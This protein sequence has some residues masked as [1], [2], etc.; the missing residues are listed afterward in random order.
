MRHWPAALVLVLVVGG[1]NPGGT[2]HERLGDQAAEKGDYTGALAEYQAALAAQPS[3][4]IYAK[5]GA[6]AL[7]K[8]SLREAAEAY[9]NL[10]ADDPSRMDEAATGLDQVAAAAEKG[11]DATAL[12]AAVSALRDIAPER[13]AGRH[14]L[15]LVRLGGLAAPEAQA[16]LP[17]AIAAA[18]DPGVADSLLVAYGAALR[19]TT[20][21]DQAMSAFQAVR[22]R[23]HDGTLLARADSGIAA[24]G[25]Q[26]G[27]QA[28]TVNQPWVAEK[29][30]LAVVAADASGPLG[31]RA[32]FGLG[33]LRLAE[34][35][36]LGAALAYQQVASTGGANDSLAKAA[37]LKLNALGAA[38]SKADSSPART[39]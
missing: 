10:V 24:C 4:R 8:G 20:A 19:E 35:D 34:G 2:D 28:L 36:V 5:E 32:R 23:S 13:L 1:C 15:A 17:A 12:F 31:R 22:R 9:R 21:C 33:D 27:Q 26:L 6:A 29:W 25:L 37:A 14:A 38:P 30:F 11:G 18:P 16:V 3:G 39:P 7:H